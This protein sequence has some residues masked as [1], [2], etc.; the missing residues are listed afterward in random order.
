MART[1]PLEALSSVGRSV[2]TR[3]FVPRGSLLIVQV[4]LSLALL[5]TAG[6]L[7]RSLRN[8]EAQPL[9]FVPTD[10][11]VF[12]IDPPAIAGDIERL[13]ALFTRIEEAIRR[14]SGVERVSYSMYSPME[15]NNWSGRISIAGQ[16]DDPEQPKGSSWNRVSAGFFETLGTRV[17]RGRGIDARDLPGARGVAVINQTFARRYFDTAD[18]IGQR[19]GFVDASHAGDFEIVGVVDD[20]KFAGAQQPEVRPMLFIPSF[21][22]V[23]YADA[24]ARS[25]QARSTLPRTIVVQ[26]APGAPSIESGV[27]RA[28]ADA[29]PDI[30]VLRV[31]PMTLQVN[32]N[33]RIER[34]L[35]RL[36]TIY[37]GLALGLA[38]LG[39]YG[40]TAYGVSQRRRE[41][42]VRMALGA[43]RLGV[44]QTCLRGPLV[45][46]SV[47]LIIGLAVSVAIG[48]AIASQLYGVSGFDVA[49]FAVAV[50]TLLASCLIAATLP[51]RRAASVNPAVVLRQ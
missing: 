21:Q 17:L 31:L 42:G 10:R 46:T 34:L 35:S 2:S 27:R 6:L 25:V 12:H 29:D 33:F 41:I 48:Q 50:V 16:P 36:L 43:D 30:N 18:P 7:A 38:L 49:A 37:G 45:Q 13:S 8:L 23:E 26:T 4:A 32:G 44:V 11:T 3:S 39:L 40:V 5:T 1:P 28:L 51:A 14:I 47:G 24:T 9:G 15:G 22:T 20:V 19:V